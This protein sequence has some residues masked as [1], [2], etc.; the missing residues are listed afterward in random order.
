[1]LNLLIYFKKP[2]NDNMNETIILVVLKPVY[3]KTFSLKILECLLEL[4]TNIDTSRATVILY[5]LHYLLQA[6][7]SMQ[8]QTNSDN[9]TLKIETTKRSHLKLCT[10]YLRYDFI[11]KNEKYY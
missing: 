3:S 6:T 8:A 9:C 4:A 11:F 5:Y 1:M 2:E 10:H 7:L